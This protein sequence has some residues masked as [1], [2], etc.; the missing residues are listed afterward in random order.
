[1]LKYTPTSKQSLA[2]LMNRT[3]TQYSGYYN[4]G[5]DPKNLPSRPPNIIISKKISG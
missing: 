3:G 1:M 5:L 2:D 4:S